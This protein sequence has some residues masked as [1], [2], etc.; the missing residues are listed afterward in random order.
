MEKITKEGILYTLGEFLMT[1]NDAVEDVL[2]P[3]EQ[4]DCFLAVLKDGKTF[5]I[6]VRE[7]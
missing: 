2:Y 7:K 3:R 1:E 5:E 4:E 6:S